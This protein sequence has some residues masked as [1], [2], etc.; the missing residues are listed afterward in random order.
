MRANFFLG[1]YH[2]TKMGEV[3]RKYQLH[4]NPGKLF[5]EHCTKTYHLLFYASFSLKQTYLLNLT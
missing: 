5:E 4:K 3:P 1:K 2:E